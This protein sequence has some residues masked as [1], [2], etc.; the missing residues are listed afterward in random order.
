M[1]DTNYLLRDHVVVEFK[2]ML[3]K[4][5]LKAACGSEYVLV[6]KFTNWL[7]SKRPRSNRSYAYRLLE[8][9]YSSRSKYEPAPPI[10]DESLCNP[11]DGCLLVFTILLELGRGD[12]IAGFHRQGIA[13]SLP[14][15]LLTLRSTLAR[16]DV[17]ELPD[18]TDLADKF[19][20]MQWRFCAKQ[21]S[22]Y[23][24]R[25]LPDNTIIPIHKKEKIKK[26]GTA[27]VWMILV[28]EEFVSEDLREVA[29]SSGFLD[30]SDGL[31]FV[32]SPNPS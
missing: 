19:D 5:T 12:L 24:G 11:R 18:A 6:E 4:C 15:D 27:E 21:L 8:V 9:V 2:E 7:R 23:M 30:P 17:S 13:D 14:I 20:Q 16:I 29:K 10:S 3:K 31:G 26:G 22:L 1:A 28:L 25:D 32:G